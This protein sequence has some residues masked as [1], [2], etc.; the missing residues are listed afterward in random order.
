MR[1]TLDLPV[2][3]VEEA[4]QLLRFRSKRDT[5]VHALRELIRRRRLEE[6]KALAGRVPLEL[7]L[8]RSRRRPR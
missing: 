5:V 7:D 2:E 6:L 4:M 8:G 1:T 3:L